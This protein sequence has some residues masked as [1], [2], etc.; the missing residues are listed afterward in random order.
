MSRPFLMNYETLMTL[1]K[2]VQRD[3]NKSIEEN[4]VEVIPKKSGINKRVKKANIIDIDMDSIPDLTFDVDS[5]IMF[6]GIP[7]FD[8]IIEG[9]N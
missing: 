3:V 9:D 7:N 2:L 1:K 5:A 4:S 6:H 8:V